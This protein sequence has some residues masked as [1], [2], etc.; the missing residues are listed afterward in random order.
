M[1]KLLII[2]FI[3]IITGRAE[4]S[5]P[6]DKRTIVPLWGAIRPYEALY[7]A[8][9]LVESSNNPMAVNKTEKAY[10]ILQIRPVRLDDY[11]QR[12]GKRHSLQDCF[13]ESVS[14]R[15]WL[16]YAS[17]Y[18]PSDQETIARRWNGS[19][20]KTIE[21]WSKVKKELKKQK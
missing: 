3:A 17:K 5:A 16:Y 7:K 12:T 11:H 20:K 1:K 10:G 21:Y 8:M 14:K 2:L 19:G 15:I 4:L 13:K 18:H 6:E 9:C